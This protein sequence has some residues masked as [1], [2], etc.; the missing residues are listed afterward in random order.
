MQVFFIRKHKRAFVRRITHRLSELVKKYPERIAGRII[1]RLLWPPTTVA[2]LAHGE[3]D[4][5][6]TLELNGKHHLPGGFVKRGEGL[7][8]AARRE[9]EEETGFSVEIGD[10][11]DIGENGSGGPEVFFEGKVEEGEIDGSWEGRPVFTEG[12]ELKDITWRLEHS[13]VRQY[14]F[15][16]EYGD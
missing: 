2:V 10:I 3:N 4:D 9:V 5:I 12:E 6:L 11:L 14:L 15:P 16:D 7:R 1:S 8:E 13:H